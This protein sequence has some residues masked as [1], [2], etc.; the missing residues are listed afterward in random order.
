MV[1]EGWYQGGTC[2]TETV[3]HLDCVCGYTNYTCGKMIQNCI[4]IVVMSNF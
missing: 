3:L 2:G 1:I 4:H